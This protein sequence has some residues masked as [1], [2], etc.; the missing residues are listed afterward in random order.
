MIKNDYIFA[1]VKILPDSPGVYFMKDTSGSIIYIGKAKSIKK[2]VSSYFNDGV[3]DVKTEALL[4]HITDFDY[5]IT[6]NEVEALI[7]EAE[8]V[9]K[10]KPHYNILLKDQKSFPFIA[11]TNEMYPKIIKARNVIKPDTTINSRYKKYYG[12]FVDA[13]HVDNIIKFILNNFKVRRCKLDFP[14]KNIAKP[15][16]YYHINKCNGPC[17]NLET[18]AEYGE[19]ISNISMLLDGEVDKLIDKLECKM[20]DYAKS[21]KFEDAKIIRDE[22]EILKTITVEQSIHIPESNDKDIIGIYGERT[23]YTIVLLNIRNGKLSDKKSFNMEGLG[24]LA[25]ILRAF[26]MQYY[27]IDELTPKEIIMPLEPT[28]ISILTEWINKK[29][30]EEILLTVSKEN[31]GLIKIANE[32]AKHTYREMHLIKEIPPAIIRLQNVFKLET[33]PKIIESFDIAH[34][35]GTYTMAG[36][37]RFVNGLPDNK[38]YRLFNIKTVTGIDDF[39]SIKEAVYRRYKRLRDEKIKMPD[40]ILIDG[41]KGQLTSAIEALNELEV[42]GLKII[43]LAKRNEEIY[44]PNR[45]IPLILEDNDVGRLFLQK[46]RDETHRFINTSHGNKRSKEMLKSELENIKGVGSKTIERL[47]IVFD[48]ID[49][50][51]SASLDDLK[52]VSGIKHSVVEAIHE[53]FHKK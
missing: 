31:E 45:K 15:C 41:G 10:H 8:L 12:P 44:L 33:P 48:G 40:L 4:K 26:L 3:K 20:K 47:Y 32:N 18:E 2:R 16:L 53:Y 14:L 43:A 1:K 35:Q 11:I 42:K 7:L 52:K 29:T 37:V 50:I 34:I 17:A 22:I 24:N 25:D 5:I 6:D 30:S 28:E 13:E 36:M 19:M 46:V 27:I 38:S 51:K 23:N 9:Q 49:S 21:L 39:A